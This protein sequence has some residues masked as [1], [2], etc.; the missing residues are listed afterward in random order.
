MK[1]N[2]VSFLNQIMIVTMYQIW[3]MFELTKLC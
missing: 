2:Y 3:D 1:N